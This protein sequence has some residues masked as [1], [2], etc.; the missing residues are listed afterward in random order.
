MV[1]SVET[2]NQVSAEATNVIKGG[3]P[4]LRAIE[5]HPSGPLFELTTVYLGSLREYRKRSGVRS[6]ADEVAMRIVV[7]KL[8]EFVKKLVVDWAQTEGLDVKVSVETRA[9][10]PGSLDLRVDLANFP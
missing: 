2:S 4:L 6:K 5:K 3:E 9:V 1:E 10:E 7:A 8:A